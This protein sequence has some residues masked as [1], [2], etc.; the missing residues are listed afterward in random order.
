MGYAYH[1]A[2]LPDRGSSL[3]QRAVQIQDELASDKTRQSHADSAGEP[4]D[5]R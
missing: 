5:L 4:N 3:L 1:Q 2:R